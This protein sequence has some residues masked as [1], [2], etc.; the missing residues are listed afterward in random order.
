MV[1]T[2]QSILR[3]HFPS[4]CASR[5]LPVFI[6]RAAYAMMNCRTAFYGGH[7]Q[8]CPEGHVAR[9]W[10]NSCK[11][12][13]CPQCAALATERWL[14]RTRSRLL[15]CAHF[16]VVFTLP[17]ELNALW[18]WNTKVMTGL[19]FGAVRDT[20][21]ELLGDER[22]LGATPGYLQSLH[23][24]G[25]SLPL[26]PHMHVLVSAGGL[27]E[28]GEWRDTR[29]DYLLPVKVLKALFRGKMRAAVRDALEGGELVAPGEM[30]AS[31]VRSLLNQLGRKDW[32]VRIQ[33][34]YGHGNGVVTYL[35][36]YVRGGPISNHR[37]VWADAEQVR[38]RYTDHRDGEDKVMTLSPEDFLQ[39][40]FL[41]VPDPGTQRVRYYGLY[42]HGKREALAHCRELL[43]QPPIEEPEELDWQTYC[44]R[45]GLVDQTRCPV[46]GR[47]LICTDFFHRG[48]LP[49]PLATEYAWA[50]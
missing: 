6:R 10:C 27:T 49:P 13:A 17:H 16:H 44:E 8:R 9:L 7:V 26:H 1:A 19:L 35:A 42:A 45:R 15:N 36:R 46:C 41:H 22:Y 3:D 11:H 50:A 24:W 20:L 4:F 23:T 43:D 38:F 2:V 48:D 12:R 39:R 28:A 25:R 34:R 14:E 21:S 18:M 33:T 29:K 30:R 37:V 40:L 32:N 31:Q 47:V 5:R